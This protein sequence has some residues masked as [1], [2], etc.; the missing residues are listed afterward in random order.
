MDKKKDT[1]ICTWAIPKFPRKLKAAFAA[2]CRANDTFIR[3]R[4][5]HLIASDLRAGGVNIPPFK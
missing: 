3:D 1:N 4:V 2:Y 5:A